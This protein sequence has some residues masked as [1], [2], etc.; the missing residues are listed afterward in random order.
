[1][2]IQFCTDF[3][4]FGEALKDALTNGVFP[5][6][7]VQDVRAKGD[8][9]VTDVDPGT[10]DQFFDLCVAFAAEGAEREVSGAGHRAPTLLLGLLLFAEGDDVINEAVGLG[11][12]SGHKA[13]P[14]GVFFYRIETL[15][16]VVGKNFI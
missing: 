6:F 1:M 12:L 8:A 15:A 11:V 9:V 4:G 2:T 3:A 13:I 16:C 10:G 14:I 7:T 5:N